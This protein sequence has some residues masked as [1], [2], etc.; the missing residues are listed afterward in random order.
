MTLPCWGEYDHVRFPGQQRLLTPALKF[1]AREH[2]R[3]RAGPGVA[4]RRRMSELDEE[5]GEVTSGYFLGARRRLSRR[6]TSSKYFDQEVKRS[7]TYIWGG[8]IDWG[9]GKGWCKGAK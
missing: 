7:R 9:L 6:R 3:G 5:R 2:L 8:G 4:L 1:A